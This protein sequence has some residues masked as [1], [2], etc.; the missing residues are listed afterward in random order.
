MTEPNIHVDKNCKIEEFERWKVDD[1]KRYIRRRS[2]RSVHIHTCIIRRRSVRFITHNYNWNSSVSRMTKDLNLETLEDRRTTNSLCMLY[3]IINK[4]VAV[5]P[6]EHLEW[7]NTCTRRKHNLQLVQIR[8][9]T[10]N[11]K[12]SFF[13]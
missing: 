11:Y 10:N 12:Y 1:L 13:S 8:A 4:T 7:S 5:T 9:S 2:V 6:D 3:K